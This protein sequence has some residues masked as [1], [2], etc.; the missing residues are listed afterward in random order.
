MFGHET[1][2]QVNNVD[3]VLGYFNSELMDKLL[4]NENKVSVTKPQANEIKSMITDP[5][6]QAKAKF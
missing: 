5:F 2:L 4:I 3:G 6:M 1:Y